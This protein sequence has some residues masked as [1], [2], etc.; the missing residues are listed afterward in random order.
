MPQFSPVWIIA[1]LI[2]LSVHEWAHAFVADRLGDPTPRSHGRLTLNPISHLDFLG[3]LLFFTVGFGWA[4]PVP[5]D[6]R[7]FRNPTRGSILTAAAGPLSNLLLAILSYVLLGTLIRLH[8]TLLQETGMREIFSAATSAALLKQ[9]L[10][11]ML[12]INLGLMAFN[13]L[14]IAPLD[15]ATVA[16]IIIPWHWHDS[17]E[18][19]EQRGPIILLILLIA[20]SFLPFSPLLIWIEGI[21]RGIL[22][23]CALVFPF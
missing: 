4:K 2:A 17:Y 12:M 23:L 11:S 14:P 19:I 10:Q 15:G 18:R 9:F 7:N 20:G 22:S 16:K 13:L 21:S 3:A 8:P 5:I 1:I 6:P